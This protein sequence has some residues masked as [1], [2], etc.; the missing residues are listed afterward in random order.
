MNELLA[1]FLETEKAKGA[2]KQNLIGLKKRVPC[3]LHY[4]SERDISLG[5]LKMR[6]ALAYQGSLIETRTR[7][8]LKYATSTVLAG[9]SAAS[10][11][12]DFLKGKG[13]VPA[14]PFREIRKVRQVR[15]LPGNILK[16]KEMDRFLERLAHFEE[17]K[18]LK[19]RV[20]RYRVHVIAE[21]MYAS[22]LRISEVADLAVNDIDLRRSLIE[23]REGK[24]GRART[25]FLTEYAREVLRVY[26]EK[27]RPLVFS[28][29]NERNGELLFGTGWGWLGHV[30]NGTLKAVALEAE[31]PAPTSH[32]F[33]HALGCHLLRSGC[34]IR[35][36]QQILGH[37]RLATTEIYTRVEK[38]DLKAVMD[39]HH[40]R[41][42]R[43]IDRE[44]AG[45]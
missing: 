41:Q 39:R 44:A 43:R 14:N 3:L 10:T 33:R 4:L 36:I 26:L 13:L 8:G 1:E 35:H 11:F 22:G 28:E 29:W 31:T 7:E 6:G 34:G 37:R 12:Y 18:T 24:G 23:V 16:E 20:F 32:G 15:R 40:P 17:G 5:A 45:L 9:V 42:L 25:A 27:M 21:L 2:R 30:V 38:E 19:H